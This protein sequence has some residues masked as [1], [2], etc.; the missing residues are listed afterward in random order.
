MQV[1]TNTVKWFTITVIYLNS[2]KSTKLDY[3]TSLISNGN[4]K[5]QSNALICLTHPVSGTTRG[6]WHIQG[7]HPPSGSWK[8]IELRCQ[9]PRHLM[10]N[11]L[12]RL[13]GLP[14]WWY[15][16]VGG[17]YVVLPANVKPHVIAA[18]FNMETP[19]D[20]TEQGQM[21]VCAK[22]IVYRRVILH[23]IVAK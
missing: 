23:H 1:E 7:R 9:M 10:S 8:Y 17:G 19:I 16:H 21:Q 6:E 15:C 18:V 3:D 13:L 12:L 4:R 2:N 22:V 20:G 11:S 14:Q 5:L